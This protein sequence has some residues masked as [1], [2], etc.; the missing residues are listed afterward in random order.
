VG[1]CNDAIRRRKVKPPRT[2]AQQGN[3]CLFSPTIVKIRS[4][5]CHAF[6]L[7]SLHN[8]QSALHERGVLAAADGKYV[9]KLRQSAPALCAEQLLPWCST[10]TPSVVTITQVPYS[11]GPGL[12]SRPCLLTTLVS[13]G[14]SKKSPNTTYF[15]TNSPSL[16]P[17]TVIETIRNLIRPGTLAVRLTANKTAGHLL[18][19]LLGNNGPSTSH[20]LFTVLITAQ[21]ALLILEAA[22]DTIQSYVF[23][24][25]RTT[26]H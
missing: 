22:V 12:H 4:R 24:I 17:F 19:T 2:L 16:I 7:L 3:V 9:T 5:R 26:G 1:T 13:F 6:Q 18:L 15:S 10:A 20:T 21:I 25:L 14:T 11:R 8:S 23:A